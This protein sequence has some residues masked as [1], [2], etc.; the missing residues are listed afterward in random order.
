VKPDTVVGWNGAGLRLYWRWRSRKN[1][2]KVTVDLPVFRGQEVE[3][4][5]FQRTL[6]AGPVA[7]NAYWP[8]VWVQ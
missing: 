7:G 4:R 6:A 8:T 5:G 3:I 2:Q 1:W